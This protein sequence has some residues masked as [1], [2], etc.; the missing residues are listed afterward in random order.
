MP[1]IP[2]YRLEK[3]YSAKTI[4]AVR[5]LELVEEQFWQALRFGIGK[6]Y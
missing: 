4:L 5:V 3:E 1:R 2:A 6:N